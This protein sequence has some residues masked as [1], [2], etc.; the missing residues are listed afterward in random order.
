MAGRRCE[1]GTVGGE[2]AWHRGMEADGV[3]LEVSLLCA[4]VPVEA[5]LR[6]QLVEPRR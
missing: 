3:W 2:Q 4:C 1:A 5:W 6:L